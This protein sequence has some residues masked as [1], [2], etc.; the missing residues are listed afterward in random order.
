MALGCPSEAGSKT[1]KG[2]AIFPV[3]TLRSVAGCETP[4]SRPA[5]SLFTTPEFTA[6]LVDAGPFPDGWSSWYFGVLY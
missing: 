6:G 1:S 2:G 3:S 5:L 4:R